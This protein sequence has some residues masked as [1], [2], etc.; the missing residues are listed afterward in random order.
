MFNKFSFY[1]G[2]NLGRDVIDVHIVDCSYHGKNGMLSFIDSFTLRTTED[3]GQRIDPA[4][5]IT[6]SDAQQ[7]MNELWRIGIR[8]SDGTGS[9][10][11]L[12]ATEKHLDDM[13]SLVFHNQNIKQNK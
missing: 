3:V 8:P 4:L 10:G 9:L 7:M 2:R 11:Q 5:S 12:A 13:R 6:E 1:F